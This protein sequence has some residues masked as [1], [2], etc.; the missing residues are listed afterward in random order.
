MTAVNWK[1]IVSSAAVIVLGGLLAGVF[2][3]QNFDQGVMFP[4]LGDQDA[5]F[6]CN[7][8]D[9]EKLLVVLAVGQSIASNFGDT[10]YKPV[11]NV[12]SFY[13]GRCFT[14]ADPLPGADG[15]GGSIW[16]RLGDKLIAKGYAKNVLLV[17]IGAGGSSVSEW[18]PDG[19]YYPRL[20]DATRSLQHAGFKPGLIVWQ[21]GS[22]DVD[23]DA[24]QYSTH[25]RGFIYALPFLGIP[26]GQ[27]TRMLVATHTR[28]G[29]PAFPNLQAAQQSVIDPSKYIFAGP[30]MDTL[31]DELKYDR[32]HYNDSGL[33]VASELWLRAI[34]TVEAESSWLPLTVGTRKI[35]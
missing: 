26:L 13:N 3:Q 28:C 27:S 31:S 23:M 33:K 1:Y 7:T 35:P 14:G 20:L 5:S 17:A 10:P 4:Y 22:R 29:G 12:F 21:Q 15:T 24:Q 11:G 16:S 32:C 8:I 25:L 18:I 30:N 34:T 2:F 6:D 19:K 9:R